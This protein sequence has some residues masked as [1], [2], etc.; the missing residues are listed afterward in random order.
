[1]ESLKNLCNEKSQNIQDL[2]CLSTVI[3]GNEKIQATI[4]ATSHLPQ[5]N[6]TFKHRNVVILN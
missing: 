6:Q 2:V 3:G 5:Q 1:M 4:H